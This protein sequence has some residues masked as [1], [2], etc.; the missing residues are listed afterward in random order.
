MKD[1]ITLKELEKEV[2]A[3]LEAESK[4]FNPGVSSVKTTLSTSRIRYVTKTPVEYNMYQYLLAVVTLD[5]RRYGLLFDRNT[6]RG[7]TVELEFVKH[8][9][10]G[11]RDLNNVFQDEEWAVIS[12]FFVE[13]KIL[14]DS[15]IVNMWLWSLR[16]Y[17]QNPALM[18]KLMRSSLS[19]IVK[20]CPEAV[21]N[22]TVRIGQA[23][24]K[25]MDIQAINRAMYRA[26]MENN[27]GI[28]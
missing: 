17:H 22:G 18:R 11:H 28:I 9:L 16:E 27:E 2:E 8:M 19:E 14:E 23:G 4:A 26:I 20:N 21:R 25:L 24:D 1:Y 6:V 5:G 10:K 3:E 12:S 7:Y 13:E 15:P